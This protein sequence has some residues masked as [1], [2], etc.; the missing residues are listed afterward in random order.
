MVAPLFRRPQGLQRLS[1]GDACVLVLA[2]TLLEEPGA[3]PRLPS[4][5]GLHWAVASLPCII[6]ILLNDLLSV[7]CTHVL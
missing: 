4:Q 7:I 3:C 6:D 5:L 2:Q 1:P